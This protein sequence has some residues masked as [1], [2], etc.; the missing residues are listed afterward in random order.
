MKPQVMSPML[1]GLVWGVPFQAAAGVYS[2]SLSAGGA[3][4]GLLVADA[5][6][7]FTFAQVFTAVRSPRR[8]LPSPAP[9]QWY[10]APSMMDPSMPESL[11]ENRFDTDLNVAPVT[12]VFDSAEVPVWKGLHATGGWAGEGDFNTL[13]DGE[14]LV[15]DPMLVMHDKSE[16]DAILAPDSTAMIIP[17][18]GAV[19]LGGLGVVLMGRLR[20]RRSL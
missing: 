14:F 4:N 20:R 6:P 1:L 12:A 15:V 18:P 10:D 8:W 9:V 17:A 13:G 5:D 16:L 2:G 19:L 11:Y 3:G 7:T